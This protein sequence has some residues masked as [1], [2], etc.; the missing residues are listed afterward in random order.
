MPAALCATT[1]LGAYYGWGAAW[2]TRMRQLLPTGLGRF[3]MGPLVYLRRIAFSLVEV[4][5]ETFLV[6]L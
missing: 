4:I 5:R 3:E 6:L 1:G 2:V